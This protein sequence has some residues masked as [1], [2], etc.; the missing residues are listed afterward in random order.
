MDHNSASPGVSLEAF[1]HGCWF[2]EQKDTFDIG[3]DW[4]FWDEILCCASK[5]QCRTHSSG[6]RFWGLWCFK[7]PLCRPDHGLL[8]GLE[9]PVTEQTAMGLA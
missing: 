1:A 6:A 9:R 5:V 2:E 7:P 3:V 4:I 8:Q